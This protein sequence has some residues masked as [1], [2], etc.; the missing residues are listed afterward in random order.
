MTA[1]GV[2]AAVPPKTT[3]RV[4]GVR[5]ALV[6]L[7]TLGRTSKI[8]E[9][10]YS[11][12]SWLA[13]VIGDAP[14][15]QIEKQHLVAAANKK[16]A[17][18]TSVVTGSEPDSCTPKDTAELATAARQPDIQ[19]LEA[20]LPLTLRDCERAQS[21]LL[22]SLEKFFPE[23]P[24]L[25]IIVPDRD[26]K[27]I[28]RG[29]HTNL[30]H[31]IVAETEIVPELADRDCWNVPDPLPHKGWFYQQLIKLA[32]AD[33]ISSESYLTLDADV[34]CVKPTHPAD[35]VKGGRALCDRYRS[36]VHDEWYLWSSRVLDLP[37]S[38]WTHGVTPA[39]LQRKAVLSL[40]C[41][42]E[43]LEDQYD[44]GKERQLFS[45]RRPDGRWREFLLRR[46]PWTEYTL[47]HNYL[48]ATGQ[49]YA[50][51][52]NSHEKSVHQGGRRSV[53]HKYDWPTW[54]PEEIFDGSARCHF[55]VVQSSMQIRVREVWERVGIWLQ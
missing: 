55:I 16:P 34:L 3:D 18:A 14:L 5:E 6:D 26:E 19:S 37:P 24:F 25:W 52:F 4:E 43:N 10:Y 53:W 45:G 47:Y 12:F 54:K 41:Y 27:E 46:I 51:H 9:T 48:E 23:L 50:H 36:N 7:L 22:K 28:R 21:L 17:D 49:Y 2:A 40:A 35:F 31:R 20:V 32:M 8:I 33:H 30:P 44:S 29:L 38:R 42:L 1:G 15:F 13:S 11:S 39:V